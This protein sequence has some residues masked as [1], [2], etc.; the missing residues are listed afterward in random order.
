MEVHAEPS[1]KLLR[2]YYALVA[3]S[4]RKVVQALSVRQAIFSRVISYGLLRQYSVTCLEMCLF[5]FSFPR[6]VSRWPYYEQE[7]EREKKWFKQVFGIEVEIF[8]QMKT[9]GKHQDL[10]ENLP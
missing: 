2:C 6:W 5:G 1:L 8:R 9:L 4:K 7:E 10:L 3:V